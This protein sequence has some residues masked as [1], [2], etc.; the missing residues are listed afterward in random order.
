MIRAKV[1]NGRKIGRLYLK[2]KEKIYDSH[3]RKLLE[4]EVIKSH[5]CEKYVPY[6][7]A[8]HPMGYLIR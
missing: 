1:Y 4:L 2:S 8:Y 6:L 3:V 5:N 7:T